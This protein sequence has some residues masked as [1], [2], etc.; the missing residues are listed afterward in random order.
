MVTGF[1]I[2]A[3]KDRAQGLF[4]LVTLDKD[5]HG[6]RTNITE[7]YMQFISRERKAKYRSPLKSF[8]ILKYGC[9]YV[10]SVILGDAHTRVF[11]F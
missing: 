9:T 3:S 7:L 5:I 11:T 2:N 4:L 8:L 10:Y 1:K 6:I